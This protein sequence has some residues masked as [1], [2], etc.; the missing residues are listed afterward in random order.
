MD[1]QSHYKWELTRDELN[2]VWYALTDKEHIMRER[3]EK[4]KTEEDRARCTRL[5]NDCLDLYKQ[6][7]R[8]LH[9]YSW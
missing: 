2:T 8:M 6:I 1:R 3:A 7:N 9:I 5:A 4:A